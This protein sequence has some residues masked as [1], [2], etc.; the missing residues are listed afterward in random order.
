MIYYCFLLLLLPR[1]LCLP[2]LALYHDSDVDVF[3]VADFLDSRQYIAFVV[4]AA[5]LSIFHSGRSI[6]VLP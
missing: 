6:L 4:L 3:I 1:L 2:P 5:I